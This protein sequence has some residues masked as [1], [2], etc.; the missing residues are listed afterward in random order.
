MKITP[1]STGAWSC[2]KRLS[3][4]YLFLFH[5]FSSVF[6]LIGYL[7][8][9]IMKPKYIMLQYRQS[10]SSASFFTGATSVGT[11]AF[12]TMTGGVFIKFFKPKPRTLASLILFVE[13]F[14]AIGIFSSMFISCPTPQFSSLPKY[15]KVFLFYLNIY[16]LLFSEPS[17]CS[18]NCHCTTKVYSPVCAAD[19]ITNYFS[20]CYAGCS[21]YQSD[22]VS[23][24]VCLT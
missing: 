20:Q 16:F 8:Y 19:G 6:R 5:I 17:A 14:S 11:M 18:S 7:G 22:L 3:T 23:A 15:K 13:L 2:L 4:N 1:K 12:G 21:S 10:A 24:C 9:Y